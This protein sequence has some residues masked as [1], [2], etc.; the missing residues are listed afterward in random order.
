LGTAQFGLNYGIANQSGKIARDEVAALLHRAARA[1]VDTLDTAVAYGDSEVA[2]AEAGV[3]AWRVISKLPALPATPT[4]VSAWVFEQVQGSLE[5]LR[6]SQL[7]AVLLH[8]PADLL[9][10]FSTDYLQALE[11][12]K[13]RGLVRAVGVSIYD[14]AEL[15]GLWPRW[16]PQIVQAPFNVLDRRLAR[17]GWLA[18]LVQTGVRVHV[19]FVFLQ[20]LL[21]MPAANL[22][23]SFERWRDVL[24]GW[25]DWCE[26]QG[27]TPLQAAI[28]FV[29]AQG[30]VER[31]V[32]GV[33]SLAQLEQVLAAA[34]RPTSAPP[35]ELASDDRD[36]ID[37][38]RWS[39]A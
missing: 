19:R 33:D 2:L 21:L 20:G 22:P 27:M 23:A 14:P 9:G 37:P 6:L 34:T 38:S 1:G 15:E 16:Q 3:T 7:D 17:S 13:A 25:L 11:L 10:P 28:G 39:R 4:N 18:R 29:S 12:L 5:R 32:I 8:K 31:F 24:R 36:L 30:G 26:Q 35:D